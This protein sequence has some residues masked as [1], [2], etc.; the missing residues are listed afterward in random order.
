MSLS[1]SFQLTAVNAEFA[2]NAAGANG[3]SDSQVIAVSAEYITNAAGP[4][5]GVSNVYI[6]AVNLEVLT[7]TQTVFVGWGLPE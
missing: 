4:G 3:L 1:S 2:T 6:D 5:G 7:P